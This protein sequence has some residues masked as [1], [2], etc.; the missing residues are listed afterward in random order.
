[1]FP[2]VAV[3]RPVA[4]RPSAEE[5]RAAP[6]TSIAA[7]STGAANYYYAQNVVAVGPVPAAVLRARV[8]ADTLRPMDKPSD[9]ARMLKELVARRRQLI[10][11]CTA[12]KSQLEHVACDDFPI[13]VDVVQLI[14]YCVG[15]WSADRIRFRRSLSL[16]RCLF[17]FRP[18]ACLG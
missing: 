17:P 1:L 10:E 11:Q 2:A 12:N 7:A 4:G 6:P 9:T 14:D 3:A 15:G 16:P 5:T 18:P 13:L 8:N